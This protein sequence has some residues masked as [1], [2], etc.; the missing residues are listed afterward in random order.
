MLEAW[1]WLIIF[2]PENLMKLPMLW[3]YCS[4]FPKLCSIAKKCCNDNGLKQ[5]LDHFW[6]LVYQPR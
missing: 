2:Y 6:C 3:T 4:M 1:I 5:T